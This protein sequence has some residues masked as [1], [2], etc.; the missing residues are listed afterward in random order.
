LHLIET[1]PVDGV[2]APR[3]VKADTKVLTIEQS[4]AFL[5]QVAPH[6]LSGFFV[7]ALTTA[8]RPGEIL[9]LKWDDID[10][11]RAT[12]SVRRTIEDHKGK[13]VVGEPKTAGSRR[14]IDIPRRCVAALALQK[15]RLLAEG[16]HSVGWVFPSTAGTPLGIRN[17]SRMFKIALEEAKLPDIRLYDLRHT[18]ATIALIAGIPLKVVSERLGHASIK[19]TADTYQHVIPSLQRAAADRLDDVFGGESAT[20]AQ[21]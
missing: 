12:I 7:V 9:G 11:K 3:V 2:D 6:R 1:N 16:L 8:M 4:D 5:A 13:P 19:I 20:N 14:R 15:E 10:L 21:P 17:V 18:A